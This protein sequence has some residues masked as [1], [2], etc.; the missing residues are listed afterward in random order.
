MTFAQALAI[1]PHILR[2]VAAV[3]PTLSHAVLSDCQ[4][5]P[6]DDIQYINIIY[7]IPIKFYLS[8]ISLDEICLHWEA[9]K[10]SLSL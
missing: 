3:F 8:N 10:V 7:I 1:S 4:N 9:K 6:M 5:F 2:G